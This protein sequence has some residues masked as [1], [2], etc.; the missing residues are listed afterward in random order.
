MFVV[1]QKL[2]YFVAGRKALMYG[3]T[4]NLKEE[5]VATLKRFDIGEKFSYLPVLP[6]ASVLIPLFVRGGQLHTLLTLR[7]KEVTCDDVSVEDKC[8][9]SVWALCETFFHLCS[10]GPVQVRCVF[11]VESETPV[12]GMTLTQ[13]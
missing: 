1:L 13:P 7:S 9:L 10:W 3:T 5:T 2:R 12:T 6:K 4:M 8:C 11:L